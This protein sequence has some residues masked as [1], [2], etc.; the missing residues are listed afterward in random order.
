MR[1][2]TESSQL[3]S[4]KTPAD[5]AAATAHREWARGVGR[6]SSR[7]GRG[8]IA[9][10]G[11]SWLIF[12]PLVLCAMAV[13]LARVGGIYELD[14]GANL[15]A[16]MLLATVVMLMV[17]VVLRRRRFAAGAMLLC[18]MHV[19]MLAGAGGRAAVGPGASCDRR[20]TPEARADA[21][22][23]R[24]FHFNASREQTE[25]GI[26]DDMREWGAD[27]VSITEPSSTLGG[28]ERHLFDDRSAPRQRSGDAGAKDASGG[29]PGQRT[30]T[31]SRIAY[32]AKEIPGERVA[33]APETLVGEG[34]LASRWPMTRM[35]PLVKNDATRALIC[36][37]VE[38]P[39]GRFAVIALHPP[40]PRT[41]ERWRVGNEIVMSVPGVIEQAR[42]MG[43]PVVVVGDMNS[44]PTGARNRVLTGEAGLERCKPMMRLEGTWPTKDGVERDWA[45]FWPLTIA[46][47]DVFIEPTWHLRGW[48]RGEDRGSDHWPVIVDVEPLRANAGADTKGAVTAR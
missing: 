5:D 18:A 6:R 46:I 16:Q 34:Y 9:V 10:T 48:S 45:G 28:F 15:C 14:L 26:L 2:A 38:S 27:I 24:V 42:S 23:I 17:W 13:P 35:E 12:V 7:R 20:L 3:A 11:L 22:L 21:G 41:A 33:G 8:G 36:G 32:W 44:T 47:D 40:S 37:V 25:E 19:W 4:V 30:W 1:M 39:H 43:L 31:L 29:T